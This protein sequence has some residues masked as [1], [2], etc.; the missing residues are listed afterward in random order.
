MFASSLVI[1]GL[2]LGSFLNV[3]IA[4]VPRDESIVRP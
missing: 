2:V 4:R 1:L 3:V